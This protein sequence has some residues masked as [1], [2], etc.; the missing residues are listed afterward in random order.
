MRKL[1]LGGLLLVSV[2]S[3]FAATTQSL[4]TTTPQISSYTITEKDK[5]GNIVRSYEVTTSGNSS[6]QPLTQEQINK[7]VNNIEQQQKVMQEYFNGIMNESLKMMNSPVWAPPVIVVQT[8]APVKT[9]EQNKTK[10]NHK[11]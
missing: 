7:M 11:N 1:A 10:N 4:P 8:P 9:I 3:G 6:L 5:N 2:T